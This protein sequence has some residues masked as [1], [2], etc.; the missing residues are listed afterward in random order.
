MLQEHTETMP[1]IN[2]AGVDSNTE[3]R[4][5]KGNGQPGGAARV[6]AVAARFSQRALVLAKVEQ[7]ALGFHVQR[8]AGAAPAAGEHACRHESETR[9][10]V[11]AHTKHGSSL[12]RMQL[13][14]LGH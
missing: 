8:D 11:Q 2:L 10:S 9:V 3:S 4:A 6:D 12:P 14:Q 5:A 1:V 7:N 13:R